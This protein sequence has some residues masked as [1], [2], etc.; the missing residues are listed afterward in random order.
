M[1]EYPLIA[2]TDVLVCGAGPAGFAAAI[3]AARG[4][5]KTMLIERY[6]YPGGM[7]TG[8][9]VNPIYGYYARHIQVV[10]GIAHELI[11]ELDKLPGGT[12]GHRY[13]QDCIRQRQ[14]IGECLTG[15][16][17]KIC[18]VAGVAQVCS[19]DS[20][21]TKIAMIRML[22]AAGVTC[23]YHMFIVGVEVND[24]EIE[25]VIVQGKS[26]VGLIRAQ[27]VI[28]G[29]GDA[30]LAAQANVAF[31]KGFGKK[32][33]MK[34]PTLMFKISGVKSSHDRIRIELP[35]TKSGEESFAWLMA[36]PE[37]GEYT[38]NAPSGL[39]GFD[40]TNAELLS[41]GQEYATEATL[42]LFNWLQQNHP[43]CQQ[44]KLKGVAP[45]IGIRDSRRITGRYTLT[46]DDILSARKFPETGIANGVHPID[47]HVKDEEFGDQHL[48]VM[49]CGDYYQIPYACLVPARIT[50]LLV[51]GRSISATFLAQGSLRVMAT[52]MAIGQ[53]AG[54]AA[55]MAVKRNRPPGDLSTS[56]I[57]KHL[58]E[59]GAFLGQETNLPEWNLG[60]AHLPEDIRIKAYP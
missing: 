59:Q 40:S 18:P 31:E 9:Y 26:G 44:I 14:K 58:I 32:G 19:V 13:R 36:L 52:C 20:E 57:R 3:A 25:G 11:D 16:D 43:I 54:T 17:E 10:R 60:L 47:L 24:N 27:V 12:T 21:Y 35:E 34:P 37:D 5:V 55:A 46:E 23:Y 33:L 28:D 39:I 38:V 29:T 7:L 49:R 53:A 56:N 51:A 15:R 6:G 48:I 41:A 45:Q 1:V 4:G 50:N 42:S 30:D 8:G 22:R 2:E